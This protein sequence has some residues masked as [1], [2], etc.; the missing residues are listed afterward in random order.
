MR[1]VFVRYARSN[2]GD[3]DVAW[4]MELMKRMIRKGG[5]ER[6]SKGKLFVRI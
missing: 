4:A 3:S 5:S 2:P 1:K 6:Y